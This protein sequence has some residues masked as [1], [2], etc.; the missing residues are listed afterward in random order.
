MDLYKWIPVAARSMAWGYGRPRA[1]IVGSN[2][3]VGMDIC[4][5]DVACCQVEVSASADHPRESCVQ[6]V[7]SRN[8]VRG[9]DPESGRN[10][11]K[12]STN[13]F[14]K[15]VLKYRHPTLSLELDFC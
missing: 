11:K 6:W 15:I 14:C 8:L 12:K 4:L 10:A 5:V 9:Y 7:W 13:W 2:P 1:G 3:A